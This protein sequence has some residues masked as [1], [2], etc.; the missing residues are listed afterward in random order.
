MPL[1]NQT[2]IDNF[3]QQLRDGIVVETEHSDVTGGDLVTTTKIAL[4]HLKES[5]DYYKKLKEMEGEMEKEKTVS[6]DNALTNLEKAAP[7]SPSAPVKAP[8]GGKGGKVSTGGGSSKGGPGAPPRDVDGN[9]LVWHEETSR[10]R[11]KEE[12]MPTSLT[13]PAESHQQN[14]A[15][16]YGIKSVLPQE[17]NATVNRD[18]ANIPIAI[19]SKK[20]PYVEAMKFL[21]AEEK[22]V[23]YDFAVK[24]GKYLGNFRDFVNSKK[25]SAVNT[26]TG[27]IVDV[28]ERVTINKPLLGR[29]IPEEED[30]MK[31]AEKMIGDG[32]AANPEEDPNYIQKPFAEYKD[33]GDPKAYCATIMRAVEGDGR[34]EKDV[35][36]GKPVNISESR[37]EGLVVN[38]PKATSAAEVKRMDKIARFMEYMKPGAQGSVSAYTKCDSV[39]D[40]TDKEKPLHKN[41]DP[42]KYHWSPTSPQEK[43]REHRRLQIA[44]K[45]SDSKVSPAESDVMHKD[46]K[47]NEFKDYIRNSQSDISDS[48]LDKLGSY[49]EREQAGKTAKPATPKV[50]VKV[51]KD[52][53][54]TAEAARSLKNRA[55]KLKSKMEGLSTKI[56][57]DPGVQKEDEIGHSDKTATF[58]D[59]MSKE[60]CSGCG[61]R[62]GRLQP[63]GVKS[64]CPACHSQGTVEGGDTV[65]KGEATE[66]FVRAVHAGKQAKIAVGE[67]PD[68]AKSYSPKPLSKTARVDEIWTGEEKEKPLGK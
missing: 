44:R 5:P 14:V 15:T 25:E 64:L 60:E 65:K 23:A 54:P 35:K 67:N 46:E 39:W 42:D 10:W 30:E 51:E 68:R 59:Y 21:T 12:M 16:K 57:S 7:A 66:A 58:K 6:P 41:N 63:K 40:G 36:F 61:K 52:G 24:Q 22:K 4:A 62:V 17:A 45:K 55:V 20:Y 19:E 32:K 56:T 27:G 2:E 49:L 13:T 29:P 9:P 28:G 18:G 8:A 50:D 37:K 3:I 48:S 1:V 31:K 43:V 33:K 34:V 26:K 53:D 38:K 47:L 11:R